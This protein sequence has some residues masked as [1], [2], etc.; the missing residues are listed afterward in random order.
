M[1]GPDAMEFRPERW[2]ESWSEKTETPLGMYGNLCVFLPSEPNRGRI[3]SDPASMQG[4]PSLRE[5]EAASAGGLRKS[6]MVSTIQIMNAHPIH[7][8]VT[9]I[10][11]FLVTLIRE[12]SF[13]IPEGRNIR[14]ARPAIL[15][16]TVIGEEDKGPQLPL[17]IT[18][19]RDL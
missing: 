15:V 14:T 12:F 2:L 6:A 18:P 7:Q 3:R 9:E 5:E 8:S 19:V 16:P 1:W 13:S 4:L 10:R 17:T 11:A